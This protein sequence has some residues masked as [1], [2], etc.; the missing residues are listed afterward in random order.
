MKKILLA[1]PRGYCAGVTRAVDIVEAALEK[2]GRPIYVKH[3]IVHNVYVVRDLEKK[4][5]IFVENLSEIPSGSR[6]IF[7]AH[8]TS[9][10]VKADAKTMGLEVIDAVCP[11]VTKVHVEARRY[12]RNGY[13]IVLVGHRGHIEVEGTMGYAHMHLVENLNDVSKLEID[14]EKMVYLTQTTLS[15]DDTS[16]IISALKKKFP[17]IESPPKEDICYATTNRQNAVKELCKYAD[18]ILVVGSP[19]SSNSN[20]LVDAARHCGV[21]SYLI[22]DSMSIKNEWIRDAQVIGVTSGASVPDVLVKGVVS[23]IKGYYPSEVE[24]LEA[25]KENVQFMMPDELKP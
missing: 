21:N 14:S 22:S 6:A 11:L 10:S 7:S 3:H 24:E 1:N 9:P 18:L 12:S 17:K 16:I 19:T 8:G 15:L 23:A 20:R 13:S 2:F 25:V 4:G 5:A